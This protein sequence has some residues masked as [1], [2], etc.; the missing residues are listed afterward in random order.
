MYEFSRI[1]IENTEVAEAMSYQLELAC[2]MQEYLS[3]RCENA[4][5]MGRLELSDS[6][7][8]IVTQVQDTLNNASP[9]DALLPIQVPLLQ[10]TSMKEVGLAG[11]NIATI[12]S[13]KPLDVIPDVTTHLKRLESLPRVQSSISFKTNFDTITVDFGIDKTAKP[14]QYSISLTLRPEPAVA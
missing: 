2:Q 14:I 6:A 9:E 12:L 5:N 10:T 1:T 8:L 7:K 13:A 11:G 3:R 4:V